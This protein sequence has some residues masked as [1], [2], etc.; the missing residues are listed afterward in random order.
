MAPKR[1]GILI[2]GWLS[3][4]AGDVFALLLILGIFTRITRG[5]RASGSQA[6]WIVLTY[7]L[8]LALAFYLINVGRRAIS[9]GNG[10]APPAARFGWGRILIGVIILYNSAVVHFHLLPAQ[11]KPLQASNNVEAVTMSITEAV[12]L[13][14]CVLL[15]FSGVWRGL[16]RQTQPNVNIGC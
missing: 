6:F 12:V 3:V 14:A 8:L 9:L 4:I 13:V 15:I 11:V 2:L 10:I 5:F 1:R 16:R 7:L